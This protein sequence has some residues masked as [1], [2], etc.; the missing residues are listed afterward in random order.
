VKLTA[1]NYANEFYYTIN[2]ITKFTS[3]NFTMILYKNSSCIDELKLDITKIEYNSCIHQLKKDNNI[4]ED[5]ELIIAIIDIKNGKSPIISFGFFHPDTG[6][7]LNA[8]KS[9]SDKNVIM[10]ENII[11]LL[12]EPLGLKLLQEQKIDIFDLTSDFYNDICFH[13]E[14][15]NGKD[16]TLQDRIKTFYPNVA[17]CNNGCK[18]KGI[19]LIKLEVGC[20]CTFHDLLSNEIFRNELIGD[21]ILIKETL[22]EL[23]EIISNLNLEVLTCYKDVFDF[24]YFK[25]NIGGFIIIGFFV[26]QT[27]FFIYFYGVSYDKILRYIYSLTE[28]YILSEK[29]KDENNLLNNKIS[30][31]PKKKSLTMYVHKIH[32]QKKNKN[33]EIK[34]RNKTKSLSAKIKGT[35][36]LKLKRNNSIKN[37]SELL[38]NN[39][40]SKSINDN[41]I[42]LIA[43][44]NKLKRLSKYENLI[45]ENIDIKK[46]IEPI[47]EDMDYDDV[48]ARDK[49][50][51]CQYYGEKLSDIHMIINCFFIS[52]NIRPRSIKIAIFILTI[53]LYFLINGLFYSDSYISE[54]FNSTE[55]ETLFRFVSRSYDRFLYSTAVGNIIEYIIKYLLVEE[56]ELKKLILKKKKDKLI[57]RYEMSKLLQSIF[58]KIKILIVINYIIAIFS[59]YYLS[60]FNNVYPNIKLEWIISSLL[61]VIIVQILPFVFSL[62]ETVIR[63][64]SIKCE[65]EKLF[66]LSLLFP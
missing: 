33:N 21:N 30:F 55:K 8:T 26:I 45:D 11:N 14:S 59:W 7:K 57:L 61:I 49:R 31:P 42:N 1:K 43:K 48:I 58:N 47:I 4:D 10:Y 62:L 28:A 17:L 56:I 39:N 41:T 20:E 2:H 13:Y 27:F 63:F 24:K 54:I 38:L 32:N 18:S 40:R 65:S 23:S 6:E 3:S 64:I 35:K 34:S 25:K 12:N 60:C 53:E 52:G 44:K 9:C 15:P 37:T 50:G 29:K 66:K 46:F 36:I 19:D 51:F 5:K 22:K 16:A